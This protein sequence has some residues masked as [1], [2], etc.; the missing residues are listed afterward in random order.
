[1]SP[2]VHG[3]PGAAAPAL[4]VLL[5]SHNY[6]RFLGESLAS[7]LA[8]SFDSFEVIVLDDGSSDDSLAVAARFACDPRVRIVAHDRNEGFVATLIE[9]TGTL[10]RGEFLV[11]VSADDVVL[12]PDAFAVQV[13]RLRDEPRA[14]ACVTAFR[15]IVPGGEG[16]VRRLM[17][18]NRTITGAEFTRRVLTERE[19]SVM[20]SG[21]VI[22]ASAYH[23][24]GGYRPDLSNYGDFAL[25]LALARRGPVAVVD[26]PC[27]GYRLHEAQ[28]SGKPQRRRAVLREGL[29]V[30]RAEAAARAA[31]LPI[32]DA[33]ALRTRGADLALADAF[34][35]RRSL[36]LRRC[37]DLLALAPGIAATSGGW[38][39]AAGRALL[40]ERGWRALSAVRRRFR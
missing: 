21:T 31:G 7:V 13:A 15:K 32:S 22:R 30:L 17:P 3:E 14:V 38:W 16:E 20:H 18:G 23:A 35:G 26:R 4:S 1:M 5:L 12:D 9:G 39:L 6:A 27:Y 19:F 33:R 29:A 34:A 24:A 2:A 8:Q 36:A 25:W 40:G 10:S 28:M 11:M 37:G